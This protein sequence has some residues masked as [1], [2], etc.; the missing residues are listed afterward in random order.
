MSEP[1]TPQPSTPAEATPVQAV[2]LV[3]MRPKG[4]DDAAAVQLEQQAGELAQQVSASPED[5]QLG[6]RLSALGVKD[7]QKASKEIG[8]LK[9]RVGTMLKQRG[10]RAQRRLE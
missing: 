4:V 1:H 10:L 3:P 6:R 8:L 2:A 9:T 5:R 7:Q